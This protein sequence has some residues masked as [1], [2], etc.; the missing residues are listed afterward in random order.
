MME[1]PHRR[2]CGQ[3]PRLKASARRSLVRLASESFEQPV[4]K[5]LSK[6]LENIG[7]N[8]KQT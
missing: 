7:G 2:G 4:K 3:S 5:F 6:L 1:M 8:G